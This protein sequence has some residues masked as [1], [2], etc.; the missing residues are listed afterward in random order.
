MPEYINPNPFTVQLIG[1]N[2]ETVKVRSQQKIVLD[3]Y[4]D[5]YRAR[6]W[7][8]LVSEVS[9]TPHVSHA[10]KPKSVQAKI[11]LTRTS[12]K[13]ILPPVH[14]QPKPKKDNEP[15]VRRAQKIAKAREVRREGKQPRIVNRSGGN[16]KII[17][18][19][20][21]SVDATKLLQKNLKDNPYPI[22][23]GIGVGILSF[24][25]HDCL[26]R[27]VEAMMRHTDL[28]RTTVFISDDGST[29]PKTIQYLKE[30]QKNQHFVVIRNEKRLG[31]AGNSNRLLRCLSRF[32]YGILLND[33]VEVL[34]EG[35]EKLY[36][37]S[38]RS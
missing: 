9:K 32:K 18:R 25:R 3:D 27:S 20:V 31:V 1:P 14:Q 23:N 11:Q 24:N 37:T 33:D 7:I 29:E 17:G 28:R 22:S 19:P 26:R 21:R 13:R 4:Y 10:V 5:K 30:L 8:R 15:D 34:R 35:W 6:G 12:R 2:G 16:T 36:T 38:S